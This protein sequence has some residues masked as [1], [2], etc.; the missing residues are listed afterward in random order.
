[1]ELFSAKA[2]LVASNLRGPSTPLFAGVP[3]S[4]LLFWVPQAAPSAPVSA[5]SPTGEVQ[6]GVIADRQLIPDPGELVSL[7]ETEFERLV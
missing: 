2:S 3:I 5:C 4:Q 7:I 6:F 1:M